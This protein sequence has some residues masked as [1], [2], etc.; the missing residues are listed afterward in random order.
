MESTSTPA[1]AVS[2]VPLAEPPH[3]KTIDEPAGVATT[4]ADEGLVYGAWKA[5]ICGCFTHCMP[6]CLLA[7]CCPCVPLAQVMARIGGS[8]WTTLLTFFVIYLVGQVSAGLMRWQRAPSCRYYDDD[9]ATSYSSG[10]YVYS[11][12]FCLATIGISYVR[13]Q[14]RKAFQ[15]PGS[16][17]EDCLC[18][19]ACSWCSIAQMATQANT[20]T[21]G[22]CDCEAKGT[23]PAFQA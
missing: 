22:A 23:L 15:I 19:F 21:P 14:V 2:Y 10:V 11:V 20:Y 6:N 17:Y 13:G 9:C 18:A 7:Y 4:P 8:Y 16:S 12:A 1:A 3:E 5:D